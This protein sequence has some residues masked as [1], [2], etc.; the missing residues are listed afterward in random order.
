MTVELRLFQTSDADWVVRQH[1][2]I[3]ARDEGFDETFEP[4]VAGIVDNFLK[5]HDPAHERGW[6]AWEGDMRLGCI[7]CVRAAAE[8]AKLRLFLVLPDARGQG[9]GRRLIE[10]CM[11]FARDAGYTRMTL[12]THA[13]HRAACALYARSGWRLTESKPVRSFGQ[14]LTEQQWDIIL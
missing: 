2:M 8:T 14:D 13:E 7:F 10:A 12:W 3:Y 1:G 6:I 11:G 9:V 5:S 4:L